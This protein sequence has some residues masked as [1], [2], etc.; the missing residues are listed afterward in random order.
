[1][2]ELISRIRQL[3]RL[4][5]GP[6][7]MPY[8]P[9][10]VMGL[11]VALMILILAGAWAQTQTISVSLA[12]LLVGYEA[13]MAWLL[14]RLRQQTVRWVQTVLALFVTSLVFNML[15]LPLILILGP[16]TPGQADSRVLLLSVPLLVIAFWKFL[17]KAHIFRQALEIPFAAG[18]LIVLLLG[19]GRMVMVHYLA[20]L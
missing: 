18:V 14:L 10:W 16:V 19:L 7:D 6:Q 13:G 12:L 2:T 20:L 4:R 15:A 8:R 1:M 17:I 5:C 9:V 11:G 3:L